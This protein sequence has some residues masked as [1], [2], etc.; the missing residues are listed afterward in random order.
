LSVSPSQLEDAEVV[1]AV[2]IV[3]RSKVSEIAHRSYREVNELIPVRCHA[4]GNNEL[5]IGQK[6]ADRGIGRAQCVIELADAQG[7]WRYGLTL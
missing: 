6:R 3:V 1:L 5:T 4:P 7:A 2:R